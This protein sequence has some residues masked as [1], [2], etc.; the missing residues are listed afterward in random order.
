MPLFHVASH[1]QAAANSAEK[2]YMEYTIFV[3]KNWLLRNGL[4]AADV[5]RELSKRCGVTVDARARSINRSLG[6]MSTYSVSDSDVASKIRSAW[7]AWQ[8][9]L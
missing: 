6:D 9:E 5:S 1:F 8:K 7:L 2:S 4:T 3:S